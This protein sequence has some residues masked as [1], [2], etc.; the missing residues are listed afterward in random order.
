MI[1]VD[2]EFKKILKKCSIQ[3]QKCALRIKK[4]KNN[5]FNKREVYIKKNHK[6]NT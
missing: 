2:D 6:L 5:L 1:S 3:Q 4:I